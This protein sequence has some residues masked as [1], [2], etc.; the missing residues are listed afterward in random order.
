MDDK[1]L[2]V[3]EGINLLDRNFKIS[4]E[5]QELAGD[6]LEKLKHGIFFCSILKKDT[7]YVKCFSCPESSK[8]HIFDDMNKKAE[9]YEFHL[10]IDMMEESPKEKKQVKKQKKKKGNAKKA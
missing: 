7:T 5:A 9:L 1:D 8:C 3:P 6:C 10:E 2:E 4:K